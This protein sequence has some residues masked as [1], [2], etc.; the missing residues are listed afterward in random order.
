MGTYGV[1]AFKFQIADRMGGD[2]DIKPGRTEEL[3]PMARQ[4]LGPDVLL[5]ADANGGLDN[6]THAKAVS[7][8]LVEN[9]FTWFEE[10]FPFWEYEKVAELGTDMPLAFALGEQEYRLD[11]WQ[12][13]IHAMKYAQP[14]LHYIGGLSR[15]LRVVKMSMEAKTT[16]VPHSPKADMI[17]V[18]A[19]NVMA[20]A[21]NGFEFME[22]DAVNTKTPPDGT[23]FFTEKVFKLTDGEL[24]L[25]EGLGFGV[26]LKPGLFAKS[27]NRTTT[28]EFVV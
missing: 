27:D 10:P 25:P 26:T 8:L 22:F 2:V 17:G 1:Q 21:P 28:L 6:V 12:Q 20:A 15:A 7:Q 3:I 13:N 16:I 23:D 4:Q 19:L 18:F 9:N 5:M 24:T 14:D 11:V